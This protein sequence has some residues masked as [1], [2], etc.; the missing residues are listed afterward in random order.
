MVIQNPLAK[1]LDRL[2]HKI[3]H[4]PNACW[5]EVQ[6][7]VLLSYPY[8]KQIEPTEEEL[9]ELM[10]THKLLAIR[11]P[12]TLNHFGFVSNIVVNTNKNY[13]F[14]SMHQKARNQTRRALENCKV[15]QIDFNFLSEHGLPL[16]DDTAKRQN[17]ESQYASPDY[18]NKYCQA[19]KGVEGVTAWGSFINGQLAAFLI[20]IEVDDWVEWVVNHSATAFRNKYPNNALAFSAA[21][22]F[23]QKKNCTGIC[24]GLGSLEPTPDLDHFKQ[25]MGWRLEPVKQRL[26]FSSKLRI[27]AGLAREPILKFIGKLCPQNYKVRKTSAMI[28]LYRQQTFDVPKEADNQSHVPT[29]E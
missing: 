7:R 3:I 20:A 22:H 24:Y 17:R 9:N 26:V 21:Q 1:F 11:F 15:E 18:W 13:D 29:E 23:F 6:P 28:R 12:T 16:N 8:Y 14:N 27:M 4:S 19:A 10:T 25:R 5:Y 2:G